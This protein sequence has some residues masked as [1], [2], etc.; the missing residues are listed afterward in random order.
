MTSMQPGPRT[1]QG[2]F[3]ELDARA[4]EESRIVSTW[5]LRLRTCL[6][7]ERQ[8][9]FEQALGIAGI[10][11][12]DLS[13]QEGLRQEQMDVVLRE[14]RAPVPD[15]T[16]RLFNQARRFWQGV[17]PVRWES[18]AKRIMHPFVPLA[19]IFPVRQHF[20]ASTSP[21]PPQ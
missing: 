18:V 20:R 19:P 6:G 15:I 14:V 2:E 16:L 3:I 10:S 7:Q 17:P 13:R 21:N 5:L 9:I 1:Q 4:R 12:S 11:L 8:A